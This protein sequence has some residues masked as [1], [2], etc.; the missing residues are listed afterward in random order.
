MHC[1]QGACEG[2]AWDC[3]PGNGIWITNGAQEQFSADC[4]LLLPFKDSALV[5]MSKNN[6]NMLH[7]KQS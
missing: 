3:I 7:F 4:D 1:Q 2:K 6:R 5:G